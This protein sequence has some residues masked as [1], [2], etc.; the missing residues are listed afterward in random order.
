MMVYFFISPMD[1]ILEKYRQDKKKKLIAMLAMSFCVALLL[2]G[3]IGGWKTHLKYIQSSVMNAKTSQIHEGDIHIDIQQTE[4]IAFL[5]LRTDQ[6]MQSVKTLSLSIAYNPENIVIVSHSSGIP[7]GMLVPIGAGDGFLTLTVSFPDPRDI[8]P[9]TKIFDI[10]VRKI[11][12]WV[13]ESVNIV[14]ANFSDFDGNTYDLS[15]SGVEF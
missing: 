13:V 10:A 7:E 6:F 11:D 4:D 15:S 1:D 5:E 2:Y 9:E 12:S 14:N 3:S 8:S